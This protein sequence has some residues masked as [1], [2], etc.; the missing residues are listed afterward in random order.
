MASVRQYQ[1]TLRSWQ[2]WV[3]VQMGTDLTTAPV[4]L[5]AIAA[6]DAAI[7]GVLVKALV[8]KG[9]VTEAEIAAAADSATADPG[10]VVEEQH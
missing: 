3:A 9:V 7:L 10:W 5:R 8:D 4:A 6:A 1:A 2:N